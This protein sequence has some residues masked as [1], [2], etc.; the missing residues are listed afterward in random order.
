MTATQPARYDYAYERN[1][2]ANLFMLF[3]PFV[4]GRQVNVTDRRTKQDWAWVMKD[5]VDIHFPDAKRI[6]VVED[7]LNTHKPESLYQTFAPQAARRLLDILA[8]V[9]TPKHGSWLNMAELEFSSLGKQCL[10]RRLPDKAFL[11]TETKAWTTSRNAL[12]ACTNWRFATE[13]AR[14]KLAKLYPSI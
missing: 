3:A 7:N 12:G 6:T 8:S 9:Y 2:P 1:G 5:L 10:D 4:G 11:K 13:D 14:I